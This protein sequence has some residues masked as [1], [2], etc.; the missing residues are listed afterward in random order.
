M[1]DTLHVIRDDRRDVVYALKL[2]LYHVATPKARSTLSPEDRQIVRAALGLDHADRALTA[3]HAAISSLQTPLEWGSKQEMLVAEL[4]ALIKSYS[5]P[6]RAPVRVCR[7]RGYED[8]ALV[9][10]KNIDRMFLLSLLHDFGFIYQEDHP[11]RG[12]IVVTG[13]KNRR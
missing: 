6:C 4:R 10:K 8:A 1:A 5:S 9:C 12:S 13:K 2:I 3:I 11:K 7:R